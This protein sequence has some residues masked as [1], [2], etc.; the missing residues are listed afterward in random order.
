VSSAVYYSGD[1][2]C[3]R[4]PLRTEALEIFIAAV[5]VTYLAFAVTLLLFLGVAARRVLG[6]APASA[7]AGMQIAVGLLLLMMGVW[8]WRRRSRLRRHRELGARSTV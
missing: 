1:D 5:Y 8:T 4:F 7:T 2:S 6:G 3:P